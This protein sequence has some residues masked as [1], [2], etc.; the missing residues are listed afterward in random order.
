MHTSASLQTE[1]TPP[2]L[3]FP[4]G[5]LVFPE[6]IL[7]SNLGLGR[8]GCVEELQCLNLPMKGAEGAGGP[9]MGHQGPG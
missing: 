1:S 6:N 4:P 7:Y 5:P 9:P 2:A 8:Q 3:G